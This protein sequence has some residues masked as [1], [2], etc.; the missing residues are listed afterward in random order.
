MM[1]DADFQAFHATCCTQVEVALKAHLPDPAHAPHRLYQAMQYAV[2]GKGKRIRP[3]LVYA[4]G[5]AVGAEHAWLHHPACAVELVHAFSLVHD[6]LPAMDDDDLRRGMPTCHKQFDEAT[7]ILAGDALLTLAYQVLAEAPLPD[8][9]ANL[10]MLRDL[11]AASGAQGLVA[12]QALDIDAVGKP[13]DLPHLEHIHIHKTGLLIRACVRLGVLC[14]KDV[15]AET[16]Q[17]LDRYAK[18]IGLAFQVQDDVLDVVGNTRDT[19][20][21]SGKDAAANKPTYPALLG[22]QGARH[23]AQRLVDEA[24]AELADFDEQADP[25]RQVAHYIVQRQH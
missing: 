19:G 22:L 7:A 10:T 13:I 20:K 17:H 5:Q 6:D 2:L 15:A 18:C 1:S 14:G 12:G 16:E 9:Q 21:Q 4:A 24:L 11:F 3:L 8:P 23:M 25:L